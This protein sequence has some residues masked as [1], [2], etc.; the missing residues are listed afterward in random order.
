MAKTIFKSSDKSNFIL[1]MTEDQYSKLA[2]FGLIG[3]CFITCLLTII[4]EVSDTTTYTAATVGLAISGVICMILALIAMI[5]K[6]VSGSIILPAAVFA[7][8]IGWS[9][10]SLYNSYDYNVGFYGFPQ[11]GEGLL[12][13]IFYFC[14]FITAASI[15][16]TKGLKTFLYAIIS[17]GFLNAVI[18][19]IQIFTKKLLYISY[20]DISLLEMTVTPDGLSQSP[21]FLAMLLTL[22]LTAALTVAASDENKKWRI[23][24][25]ISACLFTFVMVFTRT[26]MG[27]CGASLGILAGIA[28]VFITKAPKI[29]LLQPAAAIAAAV[30]GITIAGTAMSGKRDGYHLCDGQIL[31]SDDAYQRISASG[32]YNPDAVDIEDTYDVYSY[33]SEKTKRI[34][35]KNKAYGTGPEQLVYP[36]IYTYSMLNQN[37]AITDLTIVNKG[38]F[39]KTYNEY[40]YTAATRGIPTLVF[41]VI[42]LALA[43][44]SGYR[45]LRRSRS[46]I[47]TAF[48]LMTVCGI[49]IFF[50]GA[51]NITYS[52]IFWACTGACFA[53]LAADN[54]SAK[55]SV[56]E[57]I[58]EKTAPAQKNDESEESM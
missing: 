50:I 45:K 6:Y 8:I 49:L 27:I 36:Q 53:K 43:V 31:W 40:L 34:I 46:E 4:P 52:P 29:R 26:L 58:A 19:I 51:S 2:S 14:F 9:T 17:V 39:D 30:I 38:T 41:T 21:I 7:A 55:N 12:A 37:A 24:S 18:A 56:T 10:V 13:T 20:R 11:R 35:E 25:V 54:T 1:N 42:L 32:N 3:A 33:L 47:S 44:I 57:E 22:S 48:F 5:K 23:F 15:R 16:R 28:A